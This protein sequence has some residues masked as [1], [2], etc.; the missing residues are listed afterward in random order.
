MLDACPVG[1]EAN[2]TTFDTRGRITACPIIARL[3]L[4]VELEALIE[5]NHHFTMPT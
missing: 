4:V 5:A 1:A 3:L 2:S